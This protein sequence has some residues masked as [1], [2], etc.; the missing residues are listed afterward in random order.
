[1]SSGITIAII[2]III[3]LVLIFLG[4]NIGLAMLLVGFVGYVYMIN[5]NAAL[6][7]VRTMPAD[8]ASKYS[9]IVIPLFT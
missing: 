8:T 6:G 5:F 1:M 3:F 2:A 4:M 7:L 9:Y